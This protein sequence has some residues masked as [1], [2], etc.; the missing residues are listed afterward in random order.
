M[1][2]HFYRYELV[3]DSES[4]NGGVLNELE[5]I[6]LPIDLESALY[7]PFEGVGKPDPSL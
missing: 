3:F 6:G 2:E 5:D 1:I 7:E 4:Q